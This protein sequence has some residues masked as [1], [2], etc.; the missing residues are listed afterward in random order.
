[1]NYL[2][3]INHFLKGKIREKYR[4]QRKFCTQMRVREQTVSNWITYY[5]RPSYR[6]ARKM[7]E[8]LNAPIAKLLP[9][10]KYGKITAN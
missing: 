3:T 6:N 10:E 1:M 7:E 5:A 2:N 8:L 9:R 4:T